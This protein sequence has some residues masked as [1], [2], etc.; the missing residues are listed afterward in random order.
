MNEQETVSENCLSF[1]GKRAALEPGIQPA[2]AGI[3]VQILDLR[4]AR[5]GMTVYC[6]NGQASC[7]PISEGMT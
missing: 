4:F 3:L 1:R 7:P 5:P 6:R 2:G